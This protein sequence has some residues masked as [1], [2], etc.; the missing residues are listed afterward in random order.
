MLPPAHHK[1]CLNSC[2]LVAQAV[3]MRRSSAASCLVPTSTKT[4]EYAV[5]DFV[6]ARRVLVVV[7]LA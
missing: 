1:R 4:S 6:Y 2:S 5:V 3:L 7:S